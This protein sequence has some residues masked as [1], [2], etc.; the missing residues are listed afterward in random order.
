M[1]ELRS[2]IMLTMLTMLTMNSDLAKEFY[3]EFGGFRQFGVFCR[4]HPHQNRPVGSVRNALRGVPG[5]ECDLVWQNTE[6][7]A[8]RALQ[9]VDDTTGPERYIAASVWDP[10]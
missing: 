9:R 2:P 3:R 8:A 7:H 6:R 10:D 1:A 5:S 4:H